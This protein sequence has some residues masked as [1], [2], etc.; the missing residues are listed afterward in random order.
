MRAPAVAPRK[1]RVVRGSRS[2]WGPQPSLQQLV[3]IQSVA[4]YDTDSGAVVGMASGVQCGEPCTPL[5]RK[6]E[7]TGREFG[8]VWSGHAFAKVI[9]P[10][11]PPEHPDDLPPVKKSE[12]NETPRHGGELWSVNSA[13]DRGTG[14]E[15]Y[16][17]RST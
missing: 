4:K 9:A 5:Y 12:K 1:G 15:A 6:G 2:R 8:V 7:N 14:C 13:S 3:L 17:N 16:C 11:P 10:P